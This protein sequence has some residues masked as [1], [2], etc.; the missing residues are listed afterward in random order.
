MIRYEISE[1][2]RIKDYNHLFLILKEYS[3]R[4]LDYKYDEKQK[5]G[6]FSFAVPKDSSP[7]I[8]ERLKESG[9]IFRVLE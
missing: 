1:M 2:R 6:T 3:A 5:Q 9:L 4:H 8:D 7:A